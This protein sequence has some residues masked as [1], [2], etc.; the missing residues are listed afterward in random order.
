MARKPARKSAPRASRP[1]SAA[2]PTAPT[3][4]REKI[5]A[6]FLALLADERFEFDR[7][8]RRRRTSRRFARAIA[9]RISLHARDPCRSYQGDRSRG[10][11]GRCQRHSRGARARAL[12]RC[13]D[14]PSRNPCAASRRRALAAAL[15]PPRPAV[16]ARA[17]WSRGALAA[18]DADSRR[19][20]RIGAARHGPRARSCGIV[21]V[22]SAHLGLRR[23]SGP[24]ADHGRARSG[25]RPRSATA[26]LD[27]GC[28]RHSGAALPVA[29]AATTAARRGL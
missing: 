4:D 24:G 27:G 1:P 28:L 29:P 14:A 2:A 22:S 12:V 6:A 7:A 17:Q 26:R 3:T 25:A 18:M 13:A 20:R 23:R 15:G 10:A 21:R 11:R 8:C 16:C 9:R 5:I 19:H